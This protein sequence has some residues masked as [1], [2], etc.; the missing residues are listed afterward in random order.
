MRNNEARDLLREAAVAEAEL[1]EAET[2]AAP[3][4][5][6]A[7]MEYAK[8]ISRR[9]AY[10]TGIPVETLFDAAVDGILHAQKV[11]KRG[12]RSGERF[13]SFAY[14]SIIRCIE[15]RKGQYYRSAAF[16]KRVNFPGENHPA[17]A[18]WWRPEKEVVDL[19]RIEAAVRPEDWQFLKDIAAI[20]AANLARKRG[21]SPQAISD[22]KLRI[23]RPLQKLLS[24]W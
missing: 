1:Q 6:A 11:W 4:E 3:G 23:I 12:H 14:R 20:G 22:R 17:L 10:D 7:A 8:N 9:R 21:V 2:G 13:S 5:I 18:R 15:W 24:K 19:S 16:R